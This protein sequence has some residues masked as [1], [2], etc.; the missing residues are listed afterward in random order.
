MNGLYKGG[1]YEKTSYF[2]NHDYNSNDCREHIYAK[3][4][5]LCRK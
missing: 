3:F 2:K 1:E 5:H 4:Y